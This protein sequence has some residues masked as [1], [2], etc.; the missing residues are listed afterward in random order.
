ML[1]FFVF[2]L[3]EEETCNNPPSEKK[4]RYG[5]PSLIQATRASVIK[6]AGKVTHDR[7]HASSTQLIVTEPSDPR[8]SSM[9]T[10]RKLKREWAT[11]YNVSA[12]PTEDCELDPLQVL[13][14]SSDIEVQSEF[15][16]I[17]II[18]SIPIFKNKTKFSQAHSF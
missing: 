13:Q 11:L 12:Q 17:Y 16:S 4:A 7:D 6:F 14:R 2:F 15:V 5:E 8:V 1:N 3:K 10:G 9:A 18:F